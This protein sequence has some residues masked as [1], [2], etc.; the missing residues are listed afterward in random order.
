M[1]ALPQSPDGNCCLTACDE[2]VVVAVPGPK[3]DDGENGTDGADGINA[4]TTTTSSFVMPAEGATVVVNVANSAW[5]AIGQILYVQTA[6]WMR[7]TALPSSTQ[8]TLRNEEN[9][10]TT[11]YVENAAPGAVIASGVK[12]CPG[13]LQGP[14]G[15]AAAALLAAN[16]LSDVANAA[17]SRGNLGLGSMATQGAGAVAI[18]GG[19]ISGITDLAVA[20]GGTG[21]SN[22][23][24]ARTNLGLVIGTDVQ[25]FNTNLTTF[26]AIAP[27]ANVQSLLGSA[28]YAA[29][30]ALL[31]VLPRYGLLGSLIGA[32]MN[33]TADQAIAIASGITKYIIRRI[34]V[35]NASTSLTTAAGGVYGAAAK[36]APVIVAATQVYS[37]LTASAKFKDLTLEAV[38]GTDI[39]TATTIYFSL[40]TPQGGAA[41][42]SIFVFGENVT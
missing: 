15:S 12:V 26:A 3:G 36:S 5:I 35:T 10:G 7:A 42:A 33:T 13:G 2:E 31:D 21:A 6:G 38:V 27:S 11:A 18:T 34:V 30:R 28:N 20:D 4:F 8:A 24:N 9:T 19:A 14:S 32:D 17:T 22:A 23:A 41:T 40:T 1:N 39:L 25:A 16:N 37:A 29:A